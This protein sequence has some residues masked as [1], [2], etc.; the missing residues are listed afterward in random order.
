MKKYIKPSI[1]V[2]DLKVKENIA[3]LPQ[4]L[5]PEVGTYNHEGNE[6]TLTTYNLAAVTTSQQ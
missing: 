5:E 3:A 6:M 1:D 2:V 4:G